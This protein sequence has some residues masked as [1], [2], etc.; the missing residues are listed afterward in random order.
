[1]GKSSLRGPAGVSTKNDGSRINQQSGVLGKGESSCKN[2][3]WKYF[4][5]SDGD[6][7]PSLNGSSE[8]GA[9]NSTEK[10]LW[11]AGSPRGY[12][13]KLAEAGRLRGGNAYTMLSSRGEPGHAVNANPRPWCGVVGDSRSKVKVD[14]VEP[15]SELP[16]DTL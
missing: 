12:I 9:P 2:W 1:M 10:S 3:T 11:S 6:C 7:I 8:Q 4:R 14:D 16:G 15:D 13:G 5:S